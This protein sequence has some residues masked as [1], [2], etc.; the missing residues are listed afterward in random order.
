VNRLAVAR[1][2]FGWDPERDTLAWADFSPIIN[3]VLIVH[4]VE[5]L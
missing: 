3:D 1:Y 2:L 5:A 4:F